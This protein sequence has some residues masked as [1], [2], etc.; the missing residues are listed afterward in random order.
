M[1]TDLATV[2]EVLRYNC[3]FRTPTQ[4]AFPIDPT[5]IFSQSILPSSSKSLL[6]PAKSGSNVNLPVAIAVPIVVFV[7]LVC[8][9][10]ICCF[11]CIR[12]RRKKSNKSR[13]SQNL[14]AR[15]QDMALQSPAPWAQMNSYPMQQDPVMTPASFAFGPSPYVYG[16][17]GT[18]V[19]FVGS[20]GRP[21]NMGV[22]KP[23][24]VGTP[25][26]TMFSDGF[27]PSEQGPDKGQAQAQ[28]FFPPPG[29][30]TSPR[31]E[32]S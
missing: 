27:T 11:L 9:L 1:M 3:H 7:V 29:A 21:L 19:G 2:I 22:A 24:W 17:P 14:N 8:A 16:D 13:A 18:G 31:N 28:T 5:K 20:D 6:A 12:H 4:T 23:D 32:G 25:Q 26:A 15:W 30:G 10:T